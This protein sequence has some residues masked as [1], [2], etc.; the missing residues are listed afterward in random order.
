MI[1]IREHWQEDGRAGRG[2]FSAFLAAVT[3]VLSASLPA[4]GQAIVINEL[5]A[6]NDATVADPDFGEYAD[7][8]EIYNP[9]SASVDLSDLFLSDD[10]AAPQKWRFP[11]SLTIRSKGYAVIWADGMDTGLHT[12]FRLAAAGEVIGLF[13]AAGNAIDVITFG[14]QTA[15]VSFGRTP[16]ASAEMRFFDQPTP[17]APNAESGFLGI[18]EAPTFSPAGG[19][20]TAATSVSISSSLQRATVRFTTDGSPPT[21]TSEIYE[22]PVPV[23]ATTVIRAAV[24][25]DGY[26]PSAVAT[27]SYLIG[28]SRSLPIVSLS[29]DPAN[30]FDDEIGIYVEGTNGIPGYCRSVPLNWNQD[31]ERPIHVEFFEPDGSMGFSIDAGVKIHGGCTR[32]YPQKSLAIYARSRYGASRIDYPIFETTGLS[33]YNNMV[34]RSSAQDWW[35]SMFRDGMIQTVIGQGMQIETQAYRPA[36]VFLNGEYWGI[37]NLREKQNEHYLEDHYGVDPD[38]VEILDGNKANL[39]GQSAHYDEMMAFMS[40]TDMTDPAALDVIDGYMDVDAYIDYLIAEIYSANADWPGNNLKQWRP[41][42]PDGRWRWMIFDMDFGFG[43]NGNGLFTSNTLALATDPNGSEWPN[44]PWSTLLLRTLLQNPTFRGEF[45]QRFA[46][47]MNTTFAPDHV[48]HTIDSLKVVIANEIPAHKARWPK[49]ISF[50]PTWEDA[51]DIMREFAEER[52]LYVRPHFYNHFGLSGSSRLTLRVEEPQAGYIDAHGVHMPGP[53]FEAVFFKDVPVRL[54]AV[55]QPGYRF[56]RWDGAS[57]SATDTTSF[58]LTENATLTA[59]FS[60]DGSSTDVTTEIPGTDRL[61]Q[62]YPNPFAERTQI[63]F[64]L[65][66]PSPVSIRVYDV[67]GRCVATLVDAGRPAGEQSVTFDGGRFTTGVYYYVFR[68]NDVAVTKRMLLVR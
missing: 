11:T 56:E 46:A 35:R 32:L 45:I 10:L 3:L 24:F 63:D 66:Q 7:W 36:V 62:N 55:P 41:G 23:F 40:S 38:A 26:V 2:V 42:T 50:T 15:D 64:E 68:T 59:I 21:P 61:H 12:N 37:H 18:A 13:D 17:G 14:P 47:H 8:L 51:I 4:T 31:W 34:L 6:A 33:S 20:Y 54:R 52:P 28:E 49:S 43:G 1:R 30:F 16:D 53:T 65:T 22:P 44:P 5:M 57:A 25:K 60:R 58:V 39:L 27:H 9:G 48:L 29:T 67:L 19:I